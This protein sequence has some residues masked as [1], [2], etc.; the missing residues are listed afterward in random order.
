MHLAQSFTVPVYVADLK[1]V[2][3]QVL[4]IFIY[5]LS[6]ILHSGQIEKNFSH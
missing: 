6:Q 5:L 3:C 4:Q 1:P 2:I